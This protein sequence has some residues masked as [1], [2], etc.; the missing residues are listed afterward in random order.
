M[1][2]R[3]LEKDYEKRINWDEYF[4]HPF[5]KTK[6]DKIINLIYY[7]EEDGINNIFGEKFV[8]NN[9]NKIELIINGKE[10]D[11]IEKYKLNKGDNNI[12][13]IIKNKLI[14]LEDMF[15]WC[16]S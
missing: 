5:F 7:I 12:K 16:E 8:E 15:N 14:D 4:K 6:N 3:L 9:K 10:N 2:K 13:I 1:I 11:L